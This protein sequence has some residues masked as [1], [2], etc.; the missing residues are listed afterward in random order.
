MSYT[1][2]GYFLIGF[3]LLAITSDRRWKPTQDYI[4]NEHSEKRPSDD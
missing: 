3:V 2:L 1:A 4:D